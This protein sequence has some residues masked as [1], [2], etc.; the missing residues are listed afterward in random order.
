M[1]KINIKNTKETKEG[2]LA[3]LQN[4]SRQEYLY[5]EYLEAEKKFLNS[6]M[7]LE[8]FGGECECEEPKE[9]LTIADGDEHYWSEYEVVKRCLVCGGY[10]NESE[11]S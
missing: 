2:I 7:N 9:A 10:I 4:K 6:L 1:K 3:G 5:D 8:K 11:W